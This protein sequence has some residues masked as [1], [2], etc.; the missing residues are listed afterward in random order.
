VPKVVKKPT[1]LVPPQ[2]L[3][4]KPAEAAALVGCS[5]RKMYDLI[6]LGQV[7]ARRLGGTWMVSRT[8]LEEMA[9][10]LDFTA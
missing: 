7:P 2:P 6:A 5:T 4:L 1:P 3:F 9:R 8:L 10:N